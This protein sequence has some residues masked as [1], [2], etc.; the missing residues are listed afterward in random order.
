[1]DADKRYLLSIEKTVG[2]AV[3]TYS[4]IKGDDSV[5]VALS[6]GKDSLVLLE[7]LANRRKRLPVTYKLTAV[8]VRIGS[9][10]Y[11]A[12][13]EFMED[14]CAGLNVPLRVIDTGINPAEQ[15]GRSV[16]FT[17]SWLRRKILF[18]FCREENCSLLAL[19]HHMDDAVET[20]MM[21]MVFNG[22]MSSMP[23]DLS[24]FEGNLHIIR[25]LL[26]LEES[27]IVEY[28]RIR[29]FPPLQK[30]CP[31]SGDSQRAAAKK[32]VASMKENNPGACRNIFKAMSNI[33]T[34]Y[35]PDK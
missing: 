7:T 33:H 24:M 20:L 30:E 10:G 21:N 9:I 22:T 31:W 12:D 6:G 11:R 25:P 8:H 32:L 29:K 16:C 23:P 2:R 5:A 26:L 14:F 18:D 1:M 13:M 4:L 27:E 35:L 34:E 15:P 3:N 17:C 28:C 19:G